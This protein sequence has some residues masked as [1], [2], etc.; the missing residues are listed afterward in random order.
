MITRCGGYPN[1]PLLGT[2]GAI[3]YNPELASQ[4][5]GY[6]MVRAPLQEA[7]TPFVLEGSQAHKGEHHKKIQHA[8]TNIIRKGVAWRTRSCGV[9]PSY[10]TWLEQRVHLVGLPWGSIQHQAQE[11]Q[12]YEVHETLRV[13]E[14][15]GTLE[16]MKTEQ[17]MLKRK[18]ETALEESRQERRLSDDFSKKARGEKESRLRIGRF[19]KA[20]TAE[21]E[22]LKEAVVALKSR[23]AE[24]EDELR[25]L[26]ERVLLLEEELMAAKLFKEHLQNQRRYNLL[27]LVKACGKADE[28]ESQLEE[29]KETLESWKQRCQDIADEVE[30]QV[31][32]ATTD[33][34][35]WK[36]RYIKLAWLANQA[37]LDIPRKLCTTEDVVD[38]T[39]T[40]REIREFLER[41]RKLYD[42]MKELSA[43][44]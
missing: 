42:R 3:N 28:A 16:Q 27:A 1:V 33:T 25:G 8:W 15:E 7:L 32:A 21:R 18:L 22:Q 10:K 9:S 29:L 31:R 17:G 26:R 20:V 24:Q 2:Q 19:L 38:P 4:Q 35:F 23:E 6:P 39:R 44:P 13:E 5:A 11:T 36:D 34:Q 40:L 43:P 41:C 30:I 14:L 12:A 37:L